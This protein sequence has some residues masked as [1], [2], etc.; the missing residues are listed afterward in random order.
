MDNHDNETVEDGPF[1]S[2]MRTSSPEEEE[3]CLRP[4][5]G[6]PLGWAMA[7]ALECGGCVIKG[8]QIYGVRIGGKFMIVRD[9]DNVTSLSVETSKWGGPDG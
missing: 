3:R 2:G 8:V 5:E 4:N 6:Y 9:P 1:L 7:V